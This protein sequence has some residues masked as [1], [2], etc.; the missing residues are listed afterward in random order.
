[1]KPKGQQPKRQRPK[2]AVAERRAAAAKAA[3]EY[4]A[5]IDAAYERE[6]TTW[7]QKILDAYTEDG[8]LALRLYTVHPP[9]KSDDFEDIFVRRRHG[10]WVQFDMNAEIVRLIPDREDVNNIVWTLIEMMLGDYDAAFSNGDADEDDDEGDLPEN[11]VLDLGSD[12]SKYWQF[13]TRRWAR[14][15]RTDPIRQAGMWI[16]AHCLDENRKRIL[17]CDQYGKLFRLR[18]GEY[19]PADAEVD[20]QVTDRHVRRAIRNLCAGDAGPLQEQAGA[21][22][23]ARFVAG[24]RP[25]DYLLY[26]VVQRGFVY[27]FTAP[28][29]TGKTA[30]NMLLAASAALERPVGDREIAK[31]R[32]LYLAGENPDD[33]RARWIALWEKMGFDPEA[34]DVHF[35]P[36]RIDIDPLKPTALAEAVHAEA[37]RLGGV[38][39]VFVDTSAAYFPGDDENN[40]VQAGRWARQLRA[41]TDLPGHPCVIVATHPTKNAP[42]YNLL[43]RGGGAFLAEMD[44][45]LTASAYDNVVRVHWQGKFRGPDFSPLHFELRNVTS[46][47]L[48]DSRGRLMPTVIA[49]ALDEDDAGPEPAAEAISDT[50][51]LLKAM[52]DNPGASMSTLARAA[53]WTIAGSGQPHKS[54]VSRTMI[55]LQRQKL[56]EARR[57]KWRLT[58]AGQKQAE[59]LC[60]G[61]DPVDDVD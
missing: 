4:Q 57:G 54:K 41:L 47:K 26:G 13:E 60:G 61:D 23:S 55:R 16:G 27:S 9:G 44:G 31:A 14:L 35:V 10:L 29:G 12:D 32:V 19:Q 46:E 39:L 6:L 43:P 50:D 30:I 25:P 5:K 49:A 40:N 58:E 33:I 11:E 59:A 53:G 1:M 56:V 8:Q 45:N 15:Q 48:R 24:F 17:R 42:D 36:G 7:A 21:V 52:L 37:S 3:A 18:D 28:T 38:H 51:T 20:E 2:R 34:I 22:S